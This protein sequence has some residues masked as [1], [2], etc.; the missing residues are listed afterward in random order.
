MELIKSKLS[1]EPENVVRESFLELCPKDAKG[2]P[3]SNGVHY[4]KLLRGENGVKKD[5]KTQKDVDGVWLYFDEGGVEKKYFIPEKYTDKNNEENFGKFHYLFE[6]FATI[7]EGTN[8]EMEFVKKGMKGF[9]D[10]RVAG[11]SPNDI[12]VI[13]DGDPGIDT[14]SIPF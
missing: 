12:P 1:Q 4:V 7:K 6:K 8:L 2:I 13:D 5:Y 10:V 9:V 3:T 14:S 11:D